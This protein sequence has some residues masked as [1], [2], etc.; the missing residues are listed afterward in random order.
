MEYA[1]K[2]CVMKFGNPAREVL[3]RLPKEYEVVSVCDPDYGNLALAQFVVPNVKYYS[4]ESKAI[5]DSDAVLIT[6]SD[7]APQLALLA[8]AY[9]KHILFAQGVDLGDRKRDIVTLSVR[10]GVDIRWNV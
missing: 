5:F 9:K 2:V 1:M 7:H 3:G 8:M 4:D 10:A 6:I